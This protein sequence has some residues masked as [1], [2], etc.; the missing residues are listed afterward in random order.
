MACVELI[1]ALKLDD[2]MK[3]YAH[4]NIVSISSLCIFIFKVDKI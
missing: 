2:F 4:A 1:R 3:S